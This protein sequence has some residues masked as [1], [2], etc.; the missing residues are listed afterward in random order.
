MARGIVW[1]V[2]QAPYLKN[3]RSSGSANASRSEMAAH[4]R[5]ATGIQSSR[6]CSATV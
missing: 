6:T 3:H 4:E 1:V 5:A 2:D